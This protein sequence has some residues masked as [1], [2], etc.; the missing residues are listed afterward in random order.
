MRSSLFAILLALAACG[1]TST[2]EPATPVGHEHAEH[3]DGEPAHEHA[4]PPELAGFHDILAPLWH[5][6]AADR[7]AQTCQRAGDMLD[8]GRRI[9]AAPVPAGAD[10]TAWQTGVRDLLAAVQAL[11]GDCSSGGAQ[12]DARFGAVHE[13]FHH[14]MELVPEPTR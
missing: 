4:L 3:A 2:P 13:N 11:Q 14:L 1:G 8:A 6:Q 10:P 12:F 5:S 7:P 9:Q